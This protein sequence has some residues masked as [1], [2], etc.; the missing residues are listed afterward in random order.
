MLININSICFTSNHIINSSVK[1]GDKI[2]NISDSIQYTD[3]ENVYE[4]IPPLDGRYRFEIS[5]MIS[6]AKIMFL[7]Q[8]Y[9]LWL[10]PRHFEGHMMYYLQFLQLDLIQSYLLLHRYK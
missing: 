1:I 8:P 6:G 5:E 3:Q 9:H 4:F 7:L 10:T 2:T